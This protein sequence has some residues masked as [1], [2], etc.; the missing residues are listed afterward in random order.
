MNFV[1]K[2]AMNIC[3][4][5]DLFDTPYG[6]GPVVIKRFMEKLMER[7]HNITIITS[8]YKN[9]E[10]LEKRENLGIYRF[11]SIVLP[12]TQGEYAFSFPNPK[13]IREIYEREKIDVIHC[14]FP[15]L[16][17]LA[18]VLEARK[19]S[20]P[21]VATNHLLSETFFSN[22]FL[23]TRKSKALFYKTLN[24]FYNHMDIV[25][26]PSLYGVKT[27]KKYGLNT[28][29][30]VLSNGINLSSFNP[31]LNYKQFLKEFKLDEDTEKILYVGRL[32]KEKGLDVLLEAYSIVNSKISDT[33]LIVVGK[34]YLQKDLEELAVKL[35]LEN[36]IFTGFISDTLLKQAYASSDIFVLSSY[37]EI[38]PLVLLEALAMGLPAI[39]TNVGGIPEMI[40]NGWNGYIVNPGDCEGLAEGIIKILTD[41]RLKERFSDNSLKMAKSHDIERSTDKLERLYNKL[42]PRD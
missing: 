13:R 2:Y 36:V 39:G 14:H 12:K 11:P 28:K 23:H 35:G 6:G 41:K 24:S 9:K 5:S 7:G 18:C 4:V 1:D 29:A 3:M 22:F 31:N 17:A 10:T 33:E 42:I 16:L 8:K 26:C 19:M 37:A 32:M 20:V 27:L 34:G 25:I 30:I 38:Q 21:S 15:S 40:I